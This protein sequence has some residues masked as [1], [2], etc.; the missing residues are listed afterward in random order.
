MPCLC[1][2]HFQVLHNLNNTHILAYLLRSFNILAYHIQPLQEFKFCS[3]VTILCKLQRLPPSGYT[4]GSSQTLHK[5]AENMESKIQKI[6]QFSV[7]DM[8]YQNYKI[9]FLCRTHSLKYIIRNLTN[10]I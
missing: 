9:T 2:N 10:F 6:L 8:L 7:V 3:F 5:C 1:H 4:D